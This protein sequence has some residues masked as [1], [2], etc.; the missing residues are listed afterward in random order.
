MAKVVSLNF[1]QTFRPEKQYIAAILELAEDSSVRTV[2][3]ISSLTGIPNGE[4]SGKVEPHIVYATYMGLISNE[5][6]NGRY[7]LSRTPLGEIVYME[8]PGLQENLTLLVCH[9]MMQRENDG[10]PLWSTIIKKIMPLYRTG[11]KKDM[12]LMELETPFDGKATAKNI[13]PFYGSFDSFFDSLGFLIDEG[14]IVKIETLQY[15]KEFIFAYA[16]AFLTYWNEVYLGQDEIT[17][18]QMD[19]LHFGVVFGWDM[20]TEY[21]VLEHL[22]DKGIIRMNRQLMPYTILKLVEVED[23][24]SRLYSELC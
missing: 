14:E 18:V 4:S 10:A 19:E 8:D 23:L 3:E 12:L 7:S 17:S 15:D 2:K 6:K 11:I 1:H 20:Q 16:I 22:A 21:E 24:Y 5:K 9:C 13:A